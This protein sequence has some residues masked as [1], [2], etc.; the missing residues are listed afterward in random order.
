MKTLRLHFHSFCLYNKGNTKIDFGA[1]LK[2][3]SEVSLN[4]QLTSMQESTSLAIMSL[5]CIYRVMFA[6]RQCSVPI[7]LRYV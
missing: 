6:V 1:K 4:L 5:H 3:I 7:F 2:E